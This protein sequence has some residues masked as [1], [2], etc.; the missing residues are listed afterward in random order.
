MLIGE[1]VFKSSLLFYT[2]IG[3]F[4]ASLIIGTLNSFLDPRNKREKQIERLKKRV[5]KLKNQIKQDGI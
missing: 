5:S 1:L 4:S 2:G 3:L